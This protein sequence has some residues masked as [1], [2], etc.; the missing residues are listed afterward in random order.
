MVEMKFENIDISIVTFNS[1]KW[2]DGFFESLS[3]QSYPT[4]LLNIYI[5]D[6]CSEDQT[7]EGLQSIQKK[8]K[9]EF[10]KI[11]IARLPNRGYGTGHN[12]NINKATSKWILVTNIDVEL[13]F[14]SLEIIISNAQ[15]D[16]ECVASWE[17]R[18]KPYE[19]PK[20]YNPFT[21]ETEWSSHACILFRST[22]LKSVGGYEE[23]IF[24]YG[25]DVELSFRLRSNGYMLRYCP[26]AVC[27]H[28]CYENIDKPKSL[29]LLGALKSNL[30]IRLRYGSLVNVIAW[31]P[32]FFGAVLVSKKYNLKLK[33]LTT[34]LRDGIAES[35]YFKVQENL[36]SVKINFNRLDYTLKRD[37]YQYKYKCSN[38]LS[39]LVSIITRTHVG[40]EELLKQAFQSVLNQTYVDIEWIVIEDGSKDSEDFMKEAAKLLKTRYI[41]T[42][43]LGRSVAGNIGLEASNGEFCMFLDDDDMLYPEHVEILV[44]ELRNNLEIGAVYSTA[45]EV[46]SE[47]LN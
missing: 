21:L 38:Y 37:G 9:V 26:K 39:P 17:F 12:F 31:F 7:V 42:E 22:F 46:P 43:K 44:A 8:Y 11:E 19:H 25:E 36:R 40:R 28:Y 3:K 45:Y 29:Q 15:N 32:I 35:Y 24:M 16:Q 5:V 13:E 23:K 14:D 33:E 6:N 47:I 34:L 30:F 27:W 1:I 41:S 2:I 20:D 10:G 4:N 18:Q